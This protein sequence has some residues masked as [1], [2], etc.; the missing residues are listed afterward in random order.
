MHVY[1]I[2]NIEGLTYRYGSVASPNIN[3][4]S[5]M[6]SGGKALNDIKIHD[7]RMLK[8]SFYMH[9]SLK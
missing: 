7:V 2:T 3:F 9:I 6:H 5:I 8:D 1:A 4:S